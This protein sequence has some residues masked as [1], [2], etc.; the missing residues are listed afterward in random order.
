MKKRAPATS[1]SNGAQSAGEGTT[2]M[3]LRKLVFDLASF[4]DVALGREFNPS[5]AFTTMTEALAYY[6]NDESKVLAAL[7]SDRVE[8]EKSVA[9]EAPISEWHPFNEDDETLSTEAASVQPANDKIVN[10]LVLNIA[11]QHFGFSKDAGKDAKRTAK[12]KAI[13][14]VKG[15]PELRGALVVM[16]SATLGK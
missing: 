5:P 12:E 10:D 7:N 6:G 4:G 2:H 15:S 13:E 8:S 16:S 9:L 14:F 1:H 11:K 3:I